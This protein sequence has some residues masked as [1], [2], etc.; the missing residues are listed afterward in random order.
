MDFYTKYYQNKSDENR[1]LCCGCVLKV[2]E[3]ERLRDFKENE[4][5]TKRAEAYD[6]ETQIGFEDVLAGGTPTAFQYIPIEKVDIGLTEAELFFAD[7][8][9]LNQM[10]SIKKL[11]PY[12]EGAIGEKEKRKM[13]KMRALVRQSAEEN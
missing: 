10:I 2:G 1:V 6:P 5:K 12:R 9:I 4:P 3:G 13:A 11:F 8:K 7:D